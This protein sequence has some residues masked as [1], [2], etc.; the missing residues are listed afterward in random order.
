[1]R[2][3]LK[4]FIST[5]LSKDLLN[6]L[7]VT[8]EGERKTAERLNSALSDEL[9]AYLNVNALVSTSGY[10]HGFLLKEE[11]LVC[12]VPIWD[13]ESIVR[14]EEPKAPELKANSET[15]LYYLKNKDPSLVKAANRSSIKNPVQK[16]DTP[17]KPTKE[18][19]A[20]DNWRLLVLL[21]LYS[22]Y[23][24]KQ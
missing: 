18:S 6:N 2:D 4:G 24:N 10:V 17:T 8:T 9:R 13:M 3:Q 15:F 1:M 14:P 12:S 7:E 23:L 16:D 19:E 20:L 21:K 22:E 5:N 11:G